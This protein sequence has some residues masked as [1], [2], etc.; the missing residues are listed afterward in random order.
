M[1]AHPMPHIPRDLFSFT[2]DLVVTCSH[3]DRLALLEVDREES[4]LLGARECQLG[5]RASCLGYAVWD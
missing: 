1:A 5:R 4:K 3:P 2:T